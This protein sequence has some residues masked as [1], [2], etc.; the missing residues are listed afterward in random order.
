MSRNLPGVSFAMLLTLAACSSPQSRWTVRVDPSVTPAERIELAAALASWRDASPC[1]LG[2]AIVDGPVGAPSDP[3][4]EDHAIEILAVDAIAS[5]EGGHAAW[6]RDGSRGSRVVLEH[7]TSD[8]GRLYFRRV[9]RHELG[10]AFGLEHAR[11]EEGCAI[12]APDPA[13]QIDDAI[14][15]LDASAFASR[16]CR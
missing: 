12:M 16:W 4:P 10:H 7:Q 15:D 8:L 1:G 2:F 6:S 3:L 5:G 11:P 9:A 14:T 13:L